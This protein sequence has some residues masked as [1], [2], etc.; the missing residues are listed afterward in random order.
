MFDLSA[1]CIIVNN[2]LLKPYVCKLYRILLTLFF[3]FLYLLTPSSFCFC[4]L[5]SNQYLV[6]FNVVVKGD[7]CTK[8]AVALALQYSHGWPSP[9]HQLARKQPFSDFHSCNPSC[10][11]CL[12]TGWLTKMLTRSQHCK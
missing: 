9:F 12:F 11:Y 3:L 1:N 6:K 10:P 8:R 7:L 4:I 5:S 2:F